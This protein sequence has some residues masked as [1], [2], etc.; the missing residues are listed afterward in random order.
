MNTTIKNIAKTTSSSFADCK[1]NDSVV[2]N[3]DSRVHKRL[4]GD[5][6]I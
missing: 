5:T 1:W 6:E 4:E 3:S 2:F